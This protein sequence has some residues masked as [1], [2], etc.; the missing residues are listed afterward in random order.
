MGLSALGKDSEINKF[1]K[2]ITLKNN[3]EFQ[4]NLKKDACI[5]LMIY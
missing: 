1:K 5:K 4:L 3:G 2:I